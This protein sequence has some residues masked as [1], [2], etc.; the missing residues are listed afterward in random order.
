MPGLAGLDSWHGRDQRVRDAVAN[1]LRLSVRRYG[2]LVL[3]SI[4][5]FV[6]AANGISHRPRSHVYD[7]QALVV[8]NKIVVSTNAL[9]QYGAT[10]FDGGDVARTVATKL[11]ISGNPA[12]LIPGRIFLQTEKDAIVY[13]VHGLSGDPAHAAKLANTAA[14]AFVTELNKPGAGVGSFAVQAPAGTPP[15]Q[16]TKTGGWQALAIGAFAGLLFGLG[17]VALT[18]LLWR[19]VATAAEVEALLGVPQLGSVT[20]PRLGRR[21][22]S[23]PIAVPGMAPLL[24]QAVRPDVDWLE[25]AS[26]P[27][28]GS[29]RARTRLTLA[30]ALALAGR[31]HVQL[32]GSDRLLTALNS[33]ID[34][35]GDGASQR[36]RRTAVGGYT[37][38]GRGLGTLTILDGVDLNAR[39]GTVPP[40]STVSVLVVPEGYHEARLRRFRAELTD[41]DL[42]GF[43]LTRPGLFR[44][45]TELILPDVA[46]DGAA[47]PA[48]VQRRS[49]GVGS[50]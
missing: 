9:P 15:R 42:N 16:S 33:H 14:A 31:R 41:D 28:A 36:G 3:V 48:P 45:A 49:R 21:R 6:L 11:H 13:S 20:I 38:M 25:L 43:V 46:P 7:A 35:G 22:F 34:P 24:R 30:L 32:L 17:L 10:I 47:S 37:E 8:A 1:R 4:I 44:R 19:P 26:P 12:T 50:G 2:W 18:L 40:A 5:I 23:G 29:T 39:L 27:G